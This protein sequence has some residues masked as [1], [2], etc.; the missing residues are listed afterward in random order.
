LLARGVAMQCPDKVAM[1]VTLG[2]PVQ[3]VSVHPLIVAI[4]EL[5]SGRSSK[6]GL[7][8]LQQPLPDTVVEVNVYSKDDGVV[9]WRT[10]T[11]LGASSVRVH[12]T[13]RGMVVS[14]EVYESLARI[15]AD[16]AAAETARESAARAARRAR[17]MSLTHLLTH[18]MVPRPHQ[19]E[20]AAA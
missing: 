4:A 9:D 1:V 2:S 10:C 11:T 15:L 6:D 7:V 20:L 17:R 16:G 8:D 12:G 5:V 3:G 14:R 19:H 18:H 13:H